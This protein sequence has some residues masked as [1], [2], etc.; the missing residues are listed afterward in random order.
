[1]AFRVVS[2]LA[3]CLRVFCCLFV[4]FS[5]LFSNVSSPL[6]EKRAG[7]FASR[8]FVCLLCTSLSL[9]VR[10]WLRLVLVALPGPFY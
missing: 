7:L 4:C 5:V 8:E 1:M 3:L 2:C 9:G 10:Y 6:G